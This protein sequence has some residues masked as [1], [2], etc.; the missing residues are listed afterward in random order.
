VAARRSKIAAAL[1]ALLLAGCTSGVKPAPTTS[2]KTPS[3]TPTSPSPS[4][5]SSS[6]RCLLPSDVHAH[7]Y[8]PD[9][10]KVL[11]CKTVTGTIYSTTPEPDGDV[12]VRMTLDPRYAYLLVGHDNGNAH[13]HGRLVIEDTCSSTPVTQP[14]AVPVCAGYH[15]PRQPFV[16][17]ARYRV[18][19]TWVADLDH[20][21]WAELHPITR[22]T[23]LSAPTPTSSSMSSGSSSAHALPFPWPSV[24][25]HPAD[26]HT[27]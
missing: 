27:E 19:G 9:R 7:V 10:L 18:T 11:G 25:F 17:G 5:S 13:Q 12:H 21:G 4:P 14:D 23:L 1:L 6:P 3:P 22:V 26:L 15:S 8:H 2:T 24:T 20:Y 16:V